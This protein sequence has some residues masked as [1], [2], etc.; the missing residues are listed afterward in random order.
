MIQN[1]EITQILH[2]L[3]PIAFLV[4]FLFFIV[5]SIILNYHWT[6]YGVAK[7]S[8]GKI[9]LWYFGFSL[10]LFFIMAISLIATIT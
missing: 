2:I 4:L 10:I 9:R 8:I 7:K 5:L 3:T 6:R 1:T